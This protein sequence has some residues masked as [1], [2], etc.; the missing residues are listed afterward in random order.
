MN[1]EAAAAFRKAFL[2]TLTSAAFVAEAKKVL[3]YAPE[4]VGY[5]RAGKILAETSSMPPE[6]VEFLKANIAKNTK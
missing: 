4:P 5:E 2:P 6:I 1:M 3:T